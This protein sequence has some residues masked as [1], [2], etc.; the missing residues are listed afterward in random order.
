MSDLT[1]LQRYHADPSKPVVA[2]WDSWL[3]DEGHS[4]YEVLAHE[5]DSLSRD[6]EVLDLACGEGYL[7][8]L[9]ARAGLNRLTGIDLSEE[10]LARARVHLGPGPRLSCEDAGALAQPSG[11]FDVVLCHL[12]LMLMSPIEPILAEIARV[13]RP[14]GCLIA[15]VNRYVVDPAFEVHRHALHRVTAGLGLGRM[16]LGD[17]RMFSPEGIGE[18]LGG[19]GFDLDTLFIRDFTVTTHGSPDEL[20]AK[21]RWMYDVYRLPAAGQDQLRR[22]ALVGFASLVD[23]DGQLAMTQGMRLVRCDVP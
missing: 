16:T 8:G 22:A 17:P 12:A 3:D 21:V 4:T 1:L 9:L 11:S 19:Q 7:L 20:W 2:H 13:L 18:L 14:G 10:E 23:D 15:V 5:T 6:A